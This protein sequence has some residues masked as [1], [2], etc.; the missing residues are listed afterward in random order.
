MGGKRKMEQ[1]KVNTSFTL[2]NLCHRS[3]LPTLI[4]DFKS[5]HAKNVSM[6]AILKM[7]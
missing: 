4:S 2:K 3:D 7:H 5:M 1:S 6:D